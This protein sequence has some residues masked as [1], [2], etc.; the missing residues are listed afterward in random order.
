MRNT[1]ATILFA[2][3]LLLY[4][5]TKLIMIAGSLYG[6]YIL[7]A[8][9]A[10]AGLVVIA[11]SIVGGITFRLIAGLLM[12]AAKKISTDILKEVLQGRL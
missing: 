12:E 1:I 2:A 8:E 4:K 11:V 7:F 9:T 5:P 3:G 10:E 6:I